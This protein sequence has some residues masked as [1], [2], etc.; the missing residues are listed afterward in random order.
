[1]YTLDLQRLYNLG[2][3]SSE[4]RMVPEKLSLMLF[5]V[6]K[7]IPYDIVMRRLEIVRLPDKQRSDM[8]DVETQLVAKS[9]DLP[10][11]SLIVD[12]LFFRQ[13]FLAY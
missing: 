3:K 13:S 8:P 1:V 10:Y 11:F 4:G 5:K 2:L 7:N 9:K 12:L 6:D